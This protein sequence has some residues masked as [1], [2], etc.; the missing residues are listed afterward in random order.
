MDPDRVEEMIL[1]Y[2][3][4]N[5]ANHDLMVKEFAGVVE[6]L[7]ILKEKGYK[8]GIVTTKRHDVALKG[9]TLNEA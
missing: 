9:I 5:I 7:Q 4:Y 2:R 1:E 6:T 3:A 8:L